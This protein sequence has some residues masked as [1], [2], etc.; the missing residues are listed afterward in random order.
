MSRPWLWL[1]IFRN[2]TATCVFANKTQNNRFGGW[3]D[4]D[5]KCRRE[6]T[7][8]RSNY[9]HFV[10]LENIMSFINVFAISLLPFLAFQHSLIHTSSDHKRILQWINLLKRTD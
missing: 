2:G 8:A 1:L 9:H 7:I 5:E 4:R 3:A 10:R 6:R